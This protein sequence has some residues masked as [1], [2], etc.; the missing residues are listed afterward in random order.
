MLENLSRV[1]RALPRKLHPE[2]ELCPG[3]EATGSQ[4]V[5]RPTKVLGEVPILEEG[6]FSGPQTLSPDR[7]QGEVDA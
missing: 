1:T 2:L 6:M 5:L 4:A 3:K 7:E